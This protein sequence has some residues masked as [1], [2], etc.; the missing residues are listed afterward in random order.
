[1]LQR[2]SGA[3]AWGGPERLDLA[4]IATVTGIVRG[5]RGGGGRA[6]DA[7]IA[8][9]MMEI[10]VFKDDELGWRPDRVPVEP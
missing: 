9:C 4:V 1:M 7:G 5:R 3:V 8:F 10:V 6:T 2:R